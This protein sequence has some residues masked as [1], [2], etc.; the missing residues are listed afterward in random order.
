VCLATA[1]GIISA[2]PLPVLFLGNGNDG[3]QQFVDVDIQDV[4]GSL[5][6][7]NSPSPNTVCT[8]LS[9]LSGSIDVSFADGS[10][11]QRTLSITVPLS[12]DQQPQEFF[13]P[14]S[15]DMSALSFIGTI[16][17]TSLTLFDG[18]TVTVSPIIS[19]SVDFTQGGG[20]INATE[21][22]GVPEPNAFSLVLIGLIAIS[23]LIAGK[24]H[25]YI[26]TNV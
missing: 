4:S 1:C 14:L 17:A 9:L 6:C 16:S 12:G 3:A 24:L 19:G 13:F 18:S 20:I 21:V 23:L 10:S 22:S 11:A 5:A 2:A 25:Q 7:A 8:D 15:P 26:Q